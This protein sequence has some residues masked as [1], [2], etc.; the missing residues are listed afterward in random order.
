M[1]LRIQVEGRAYEL[2]VGTFQPRR[3]DAFRPGLLSWNCRRRSLARV[4]HKGCLKIA[5]VA[6][7]LPGASSLFSVL[8]A[9]RSGAMS[10][11]Y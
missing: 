2:D 8:R 6:L 3:N 7:L 10:R 9:K 4:R 1:K 5:Y 11:S